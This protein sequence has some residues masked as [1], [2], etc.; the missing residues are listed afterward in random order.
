MRKGLKGPNALFCSPTGALFSH[1]KLMPYYYG[2]G[3]MFPMLKPK[4]SPVKEL[5]KFPFMHALYGGII[6][7]LGAFFR[8]R[9]ANLG[10]LT[11]NSKITI[12]EK[13]YVAK[14]MCSARFGMHTEPK[15]KTNCYLTIYLPRNEQHLQINMLHSRL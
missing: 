7:H 3:D 9:M 2:V 1:S 8:G 13:P 4:R 14:S 12:V 11:W 15:S 6:T 10:L 5:R